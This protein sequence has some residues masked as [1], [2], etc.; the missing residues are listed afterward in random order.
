EPE[1]SSDNGAENENSGDEGGTN[2][3]VGGESEG[4]AMPV[5]AVAVGNDYG[6]YHN[7]TLNN[8]Y[9]HTGVD[10][11]AEVGT[12]VFAV[13]AGVVESIYKEDLLLGTQIVVA[14]EN[15]VKSVYRFVNEKE[16]LK[17]GDSVA[18][19]DVIATVA[20]PTGNEYKDGAHLHFEITVDGKSVDPAAYLT[21]EEK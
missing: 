14:H 9:E 17:V 16:G 2:K 4:M 20:E 8:Y 6:F 12:E 18:K 13:D 15:G 3:P 5:S 19:G 7:K 11:T 1:N 21:L 10:F